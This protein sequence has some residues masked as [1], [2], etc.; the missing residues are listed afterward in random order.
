MDV[1][2]ADYGYINARIR[3][4]RSYLLDRSFYEQLITLED[5]PAMISNLEKTPYKKELD[6]CVARGEIEVMS[7]DEAFKRNL[8]RTFRKILSFTAGEHR[9]LTDILLARWDL[10][11]LKSILRGKHISATEDEILK[12]LIPAGEIDIPFLAELAK[13]PDVKSV[14]DLMITWDL[15]YAKPLREN[16]P[17]YL[18]VMKEKKSAKAEKPEEALLERG[19]GE[20]KDFEKDLAVLETALDKFYCSFA[21]KETRGRSPNSRMVGELI[22]A[23]IDITNILSLLRIQSINFAREYAHIKDDVEKAERIREKKE[24]IFIFGG[25][26]LSLNRFLLLSEVGEIEEVVTKLSGPSIGKA[27]L[28][29]MPRFFDRGSIT[30]LERKMEEIAVEKGVEMYKK[31]PLYMGIMA[32]YI[33]AKYNEVVNLRIIIRGKAIGMQE[34]KIR[35]ELIFV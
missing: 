22:V 7:I 28:E 26:E 3:A 14:I 29:V 6:E 16:L 35:E 10:H 4:M 24:E 11:N 23:Q 18:K 5:L 34:R 15:P 13:Q 8:A 17:G 27:L 25:K 33:W 12:S 32:S 19:A 30:I 1:G 21:L 20:F 2:L 31:G 9:K